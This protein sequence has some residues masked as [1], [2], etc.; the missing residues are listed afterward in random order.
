MKLT[1]LLAALLLSAG[2]AGS[3]KQPS[4]LPPSAFDLLSFHWEATEGR[5]LGIVIDNEVAALP[6]VMRPI[7][8]A[9]IPLM[10]I[11]NPELAE[12]RARRINR[13]IQRRH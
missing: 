8:A 12:W 10:Q 7:D 9:E 6:T 13:A 1:M 4:V 11:A 3:A 5:R 2:C